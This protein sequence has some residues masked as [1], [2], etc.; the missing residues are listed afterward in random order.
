MFSAR[1]LLVDLFY[2]LC[3]FWFGHDISKTM[4]VDISKGFLSRPFASPKLSSI[5]SLYVLGQI[6][7]I[8]FCVGERYGQEELTTRCVFKGKA[9]KLEV[10]QFSR[11]EQ[12]YDSSSVNGVAGQSVRIP[13]QDTDRMR[14]T[15]FDLV[16]H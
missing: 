4:V 13:T 15:V 10:N 7:H 1:K 8:V 2:D 3:L 12:I 16:E 5:S 9:W 14:K 11:I 6:V